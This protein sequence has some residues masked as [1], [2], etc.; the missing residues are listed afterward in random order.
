MGQIYRRIIPKGSFQFFSSLAPPKSKRIIFNVKTI[1]GFPIMYTGQCR[2]YPYCNSLDSFY[3]A[4]YS[5]QKANRMFTYTYP[6]ISD[7][8]GLGSNKYITLVK[9]QDDD[10]LKSGY[11]IV[12]TSFVAAQDEIETV[13]NEIFGR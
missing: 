7:E 3:S 12:D 9:C 6:Y 4:A 10:N 13:E 1:S 2:T 8:N 5:P 11:C